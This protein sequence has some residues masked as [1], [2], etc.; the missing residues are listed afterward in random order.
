M[1]AEHGYAETTVA[2]VAGH[3]GLTE[4]TF[5]RY[6]DDKKE[7]L[8]VENGLGELVAAR[9]AASNSAS[10]LE[11]AAD[12]FRAIAEQLQSEPA[13]VRRRARIVAATPELQEREMRKFSQWT[14]AV[15]QALTDKAVE[16]LP[17]RIAAEVATALFRIAYI[18]WTEAS[19]HVDLIDT[20]DALLEIHR[21]VTSASPRADTIA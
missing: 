19:D 9:T 8:F 12:G 7:V 10:V 11:Q 15:T 2:A 14:T 21:S 1:F 5:F 3:A 4:R 6:F 16:P 13:R 18:N 17:A 20:V